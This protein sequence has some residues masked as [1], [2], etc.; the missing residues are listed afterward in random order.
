MTI[1]KKGTRLIVVDNENYRWMI[2]RK[3]T[4]HQKDYGSGRLHI[5]VEKV[6]SDDRKGSVLLIISDRQHPK[7]WLTKSVKPITPF[8]VA[9]WIKK[10]IAA[11]WQADQ[12][13]ALYR[14]QV[15]DT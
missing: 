9:T 6:M 2:R 3:A 12:S 10:A 8:D 4:Y 11:G 7:D 1:P 15:A 5:A 14:Y 13:G